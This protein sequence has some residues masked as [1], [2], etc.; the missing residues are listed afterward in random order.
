[1]IYL[2]LY[3]EFFKIGLFAVGGGLSTI[4]FL[5]ELT[6][7]FPTWITRLDVANMIAISQS[8]PGPIGINMATYTGYNVVGIFGGLSATFG[9][10]SP[11]LIIVILISKFLKHFNNEWYIVDS[12]YGLRPTVL[13]LIIYAV[14]NIFV[15]TFYVNGD[16][17]ILEL[18]IFSFIFILYR[19]FSNIHPIL[20]IMVG[21]ILSIVLK[22]PY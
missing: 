4:P 9:L 12:F 3:W 15:S 18:L 8:T 5:Y 10:I 7:N 21:A 22:L 14:S 2:T 17:M 13:A 11:S 1:M 19:K 20:W 6:I 16:L